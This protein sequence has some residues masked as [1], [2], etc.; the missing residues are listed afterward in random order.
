[1]VGITHQ[2]KDEIIAAAAE[3]FCSKGYAATSMDDVRELAKVSKGGLYHH[4]P[5]KES[6]LHAVVIRLNQGTIAKLE[7]DLQEQSGSRIEK[8]QF[9]LDQKNEYRNSQLPLFG[10]LLSG[11][12]EMVVSSVVH[13]MWSVYEPLLGLLLGDGDGTACTAHILA[14]IFADLSLSMRTITTAAE[15]HATISAYEATINALVGVPDG[16]LQ[17]VKP[18]FMTNVELTFKQVIGGETWH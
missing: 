17:I 10:A 14:V 18:E 9:F 5:S 16:T 4:F 6:V 8:L 1:M 12:S 7:K 2:R 11:E 3:L 13:T 15:L